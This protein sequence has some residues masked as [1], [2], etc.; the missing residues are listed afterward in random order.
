MYIPKKITHD[1][2]CRKLSAVNSDINILGTYVKALKPIKVECAVCGHVWESTPNNLLRGHGCRKCSDKKCS[3]RLRKDHEVFLKEMKQINPNIII[4]E[5]YV[6]NS[7][8]LLCECKLDG[9]RWSPRP[10][11]LLHGKGC[12]HCKT[13][14]LKKRN[15]KTHAQ[16]ISEI[17]A[18][19]SNV[20]VVGKYVNSNTKILCR[21]PVDGYEWN[22]LPG[23]LL[24]GQGCPKCA[25][26]LKRTEEEFFKKIKQL[27]P[28]YD[29]VTKY[30]DSHTSI[31]CRCRRCFNEWETSPD[32]L[33][34]GSGCPRCLESRGERAISS[35]LTEHNILFERQ[36]KFADCKNIKC[37]PFDFF[38][39]EYNLCV[40]YD[41]EQ[42]FTPVRFGEISE[43]RAKAQF[44][45]SQTNDR[46]KTE[47]CKRNNIRLLRIPYWDYSKIDQIIKKE[48]LNYS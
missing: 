16:F 36:K 32:S 24:K 41:G 18:I 10:A 31:K 48:I 44:L 9:Y 15:T 3:D 45:K 4:L 27:H 34:N 40:E 23:N 29:V 14:A 13:E 22:A 28:N 35:I 26:I 37:L 11:D 2:F 39:P 38:I 43:E 33:L 7:T 21:C 25:G 42:H 17:S 20:I 46:I 30:I 5:R 6:D 12:P 19:S 8:N 1:D 47:Y